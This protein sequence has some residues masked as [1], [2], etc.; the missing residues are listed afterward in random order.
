M[1]KGSVSHQEEAASNLD[2]RTE[3]LDVTGLGGRTL[4]KPQ[5][6]AHAMN[7]EANRLWQPVTTGDRCCIT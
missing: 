1:E 6:F 2:G 4:A 7:S 3:Q 5:F